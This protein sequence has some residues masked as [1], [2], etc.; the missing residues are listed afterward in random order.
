MIFDKWSNLKYYQHLLPV[1]KEIKNIDF[2]HLEPGKYD[3]KDGNFF[4][5]EKS[6]LQSSMSFEAHKEYLDIHLPLKIAEKIAFSLQPFERITEA[7]DIKKD[8][9]FGKVKS[10]YYQLIV[11]PGEFILFWPQEIH[12]PK[13]QVDEKAEQKRA[14]IKIKI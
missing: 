5:I 3:L 9:M 7:Y 11:N 6:N 10:N 14:I 1:F 8:I 4:I 13:I 12:A 2:F